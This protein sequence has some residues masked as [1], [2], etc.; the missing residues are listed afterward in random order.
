MAGKGCQVCFP[1]LM[2]LWSQG[3]QRKNLHILCCVVLRSAKVIPGNEPQV[4]TMLNRLSMLG[5]RV[6]Q[7]RGDNLHTSGMGGHRLCTS[8]DSRI[9]T[10]SFPNMRIR[11]CQVQLSPYSF[12]MLLYSSPST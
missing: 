2:L 7:G 3:K 11:R 10:S 4:S 6:V 9:L 5:A 12:A 8:F 1:A